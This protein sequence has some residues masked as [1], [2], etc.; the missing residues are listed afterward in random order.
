MNALV[1]GRIAQMQLAKQARSPGRVRGGRVFELG[2]RVRVLLALAVRTRLVLRESGR[3]RAFGRVPRTRVRRRRMPRVVLLRLRL[4]TALPHTASLRALCARRVRIGHLAGRA[5]MRAAVG[6]VRKTMEERVQEDVR[7]RRLPDVALQLLQV[8][9]ASR[10]RNCRHVPQLICLPSVFW[11]VEHRNS[12]SG[13][14]VSRRPELA[15]RRWSFLNR[16]RS[17]RVGLRDHTA[18][19]AAGSRCEAKQRRRRHHHLCWS[20]RR[21]Y[22]NSLLKFGRFVGLLFNRLKIVCQPNARHRH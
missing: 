6:C 22:L 3:V 14:S 2:V 11:S 9:W 15:A 13:R 12:N 1:G 20:H 5:V 7:L 16:R 4:P 19:R 10:R 18:P 8:A 17:R 21:S